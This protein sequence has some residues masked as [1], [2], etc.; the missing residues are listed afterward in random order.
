[1]FYFSPTYLLL[2]LV[3]AAIGGAAQLYIRSTYRRFDAVPLASGRTGA[4]V[5]R[6]ML[7]SNGL[8]DVAIEQVAGQLTDHYDPRSR[9]LRLS[10][11]V[12][13][14]RSV[15][16]AGVASH[17]AG[18]A[19]QHARSHAATLLR[20]TLVPTASIGSNLAGPFII[21]GLVLQFPGLVWVG[22]VAYGLA[23]LFQ[24]V[25]LPVEFDASRRA[26]ASLAT[27]GSIPPEQVS[28]ARSV[29]NAA[30]MTYVA[31]TLVAL[32]QLLYYVGLARRD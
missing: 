29:L 28:G 13:S 17:E 15:A 10:S 18:H 11:G 1:M 22:V 7:D 19:V 14:G 2:V 21:L 27:T 20:Q 8:H 5:A 4:E 26:V 30:A 12:Y 9:V 31:A 25:T 3:M 6:I 23:V 24:F 32:I 16:A